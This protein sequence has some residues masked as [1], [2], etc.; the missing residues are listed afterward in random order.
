MNVGRNKGKYIAVLLLAFV[1]ATTGQTPV[2]TPPLLSSSTQDLFASRPPCSTKERLEGSTLKSIIAAVI[3]KSSGR[4]VNGL[5][6]SDFVLTRN[7]EEL[8]PLAFASSNTPLTAVLLFDTSPSTLGSLTQMSAA[9][10]DFIGR[11]KPDDRLSVITFDG[12][13]STIVKSTPVKDL[14]SRSIR[15]TRRAQGT[16][17]FD[18]VRF[19]L[20]SGQLKGNGRKV[21]IVFTDGRDTLSAGENENVAVDMAT[22]ND[23]LIY[24]VQYPDRGT[25]SKPK[26]DAFLSRLAEASGGRVLTIASTSEAGESFRA[27]AE[28][29]RGRYVMCYLESGDKA[30]SQMALKLR[31]P[32]PNVSLRFRVY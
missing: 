13:I 21:V 26:P 18:A 31:R 8:S 1:F 11:M 28:E 27:I 6:A 24:S 30:D 5:G 3:D 14:G 19:A 4:Y 17:L 16:R 9:A 25:G 15:L 32:D 22:E 7:G 2:T 23:A 10:N 12:E 20:G 29:V